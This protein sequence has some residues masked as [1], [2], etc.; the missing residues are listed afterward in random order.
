MLPRDSS[1]MQDA[2]QTNTDKATR[3]GRALAVA[4]L[5]RS[6]WSGHAV[7]VGLKVTDAGGGVV[8]A[9]EAMRAADR[10]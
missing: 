7:S 2:A 10:R 8:L 3:D 4:E 1:T 6:G 5:L 9:I